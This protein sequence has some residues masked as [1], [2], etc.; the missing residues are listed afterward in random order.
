MP[1]MTPPPNPYQSAP[2]KR[3]PVD[4]NDNDNDDDDKDKD[5]DIDIEHVETIPSTDRLL[6]STVPRPKKKLIKRQAIKTLTTAESSLVQELDS[7]GT[8][9]YK[10]RIRSDKDAQNSEAQYMH[11]FRKR[12]ELCTFPGTDGTFP[13]TDAAKMAV[14]RVLFENICDWGYY[15]EMRQALSEASRQVWDAHVE[16]RPSVSEAYMRSL[17]PPKNVQQRRVLGMTLSDITIETLSWRLMVRFTRH[18]GYTRGW[19]CVC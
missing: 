19:E 8:G 1:L 5:K 3:R 16:A 17:M 18:F 12:P 10:G 11:L 14:V 15:R 2:I 6:P 7:V 13:N 4:D 9:I